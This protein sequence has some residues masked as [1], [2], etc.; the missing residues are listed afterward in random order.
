[1]K[2]IL[3]RHGESEHNAGIVEGH[4][5]SLSKKGKLQS[6]KLGE[7]LKKQK[8]K[9]DKIYTSELIRSKQTAEIIS[10]IIHV[11]IKKSFESLNEYDPKNLKNKLRLLLNRRLKRLKKFLKEISREKEKEKTI[12]VVAH[13]ITNRIII[14][15]LLDL[16]LKKQLLRFRHA[17]TS[18]GILSWSK[19]FKN[20][21]ITSLNDI[22]HLQ[23]NLK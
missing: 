4:N 9:I 5:S 6:K 1:M 20:W 18:I 23:E 21:H 15:Y 11:P 3:V 8:I 17:N 13:G 2:I 7:R 22:S 12:M 19:E 14:G 10:K 16:P